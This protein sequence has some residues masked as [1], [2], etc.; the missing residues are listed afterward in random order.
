MLLHRSLVTAAVSSLLLLSG[1]AI[2]TIA[3]AA[4]PKV[5]PKPIAPAAKPPAKPPVKPSAK[6]VAQPP[7]IDKAAFLIVPG[8][9][10]GKIT[11]QIDRQQLATIFGKQNVEDFIEGGPEGQAKLPAS[12][13]KIDGKHSLDVIW[14]DD[15]KTSLNYIA[16]VD[17]RWYTA[18]GLTVNAGVAAL[19][20]KFGKFSFYGFGWDYGGLLNRGNDKLD[21]YR[22]ATG[23]NFMMHV[24]PNLCQQFPTDCRAV[25]GDKTFASDNPL[26][27]K[28][29]AHIGVLYVHL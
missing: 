7:A 4:V 3:Q 16:I 28:L 25:S 15:A 11:K 13:V 26:L 6:P 22:E 5:A 12:R 17:S 27:L 19:Q 9:S 21:Q 10:V 20:R 24:S 18:D 1:C 8:K 29:K 23:V 2:P 14:A